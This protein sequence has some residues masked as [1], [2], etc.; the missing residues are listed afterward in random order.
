MLTLDLSIQCYDQSASGVSENKLRGVL[1][2]LESSLLKSKQGFSNGALFSLCVV[3]L[4][5]RAF[6][7][8]FAQRSGRD[9][10]GGEASNVL[11]PTVIGRREDTLAV[12]FSLI[13]GS[14]RKEL[15]PLKT[16]RQT[17]G[18]ETDQGMIGPIYNHRFCSK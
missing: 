16:I 18:I 6:A 13:K 5:S 4:I 10:L 2:D 8:N 17:A 7:E 1:S 3:T 11:E 12:I 9:L 15:N 14:D